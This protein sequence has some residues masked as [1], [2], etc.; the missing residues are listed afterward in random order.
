MGWGRAGCGT[1]GI[2]REGEKPLWDSGFGGAG[3]L[4][5]CSFSEE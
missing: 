4:A 3:G 2:L 5:G 1:S